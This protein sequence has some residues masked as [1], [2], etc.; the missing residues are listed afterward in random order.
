MGAVSDDVDLSLV[1]S[2]RLWT[3]LTKRHDAIVMVHMR[4]LHGGNRGEEKF[5]GWHGGHATAIGMLRYASARLEAR[6]PVSE[7]GEKHPD[8]GYCDPRVEGD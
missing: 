1:E 7:E 3:E 5:I 6:E 2:E 4:K 8:D